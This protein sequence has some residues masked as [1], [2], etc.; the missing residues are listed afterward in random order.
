[1]GLPQWV[2][3]TVRSVT[4]VQTRVNGGVFYTALPRTGA[5]TGAAAKQ[6]TA[7][8]TAANKVGTRA[9]VLA[10]TAN[11]AEAWAEGILL[12]AATTAKLIYTIAVCTGTG[13]VTA[14]ADILGELMAIPGTATGTGAAGIFVPFMEPVYIPANVAI[15]MAIGA[16]TAAKKASFHLLVS[17]N[18]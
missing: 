1:M 15:S 4:P 6:L 9:I 11:T 8:A 13:A 2:Q 5:I 10:A 17:R 3:R 12:S 7:H 14:G 16:S 18:K